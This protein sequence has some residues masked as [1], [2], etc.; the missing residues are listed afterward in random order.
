MKNNKW[1]VPDYFKKFSCKTDKCRNTCCSR[2]RIPVSKDAYERII[3]ADLSSDLNQRIALGFKEP[4]IISDE[5]YRLIDLNWLGECQLYQD[6]LCLLHKE[7]GEQF[8]PETCRLF[9]RSYKR[10]NDQNI[11]ICSNAC[12]RTVELIYD[13]ENLNLT[14]TELNASAN[15]IS[16]VSQEDIEMILKFQKIFSDKTYTLSKNMEKVCL[17]VNEEAFKHDSLQSDDPI[18]MA[19]EVLETLVNRFSILSDYAEAVINRYRNNEELYSQDCIAF[20]ERFPDWMRFF[21]NLI[22]NSMMYENFPFVD[23]RFD[24][25]D[26]YKGLCATY[27]LLRFL[28]IGYTA[29]HP[30]KED[31][32][33]VCAAIFHLVDHSPFYYNIN[34]IVKY[35][36]LLLK[37]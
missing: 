3:A 31:L 33:D 35:P 9:P 17:L 11:A 12:E 22:N 23:R 24:K 34:V 18:Q 25:T 27:G 21:E 37:L 26:A 28:A 6:G 32:I 36:A 29:E 19:I 5:R 2:W 4:E 8:I 13:S 16:T 20:D 7:K 30:L 15:N 14:K 1:L 10:I